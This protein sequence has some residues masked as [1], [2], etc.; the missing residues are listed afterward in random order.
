M[1]TIRDVAKACGVS[2]QTVSN[3]LNSQAAVRPATRERV[4][5]AVQEVGYHPSALARGL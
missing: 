3:T 1:A 4:M 2:Y 5:R